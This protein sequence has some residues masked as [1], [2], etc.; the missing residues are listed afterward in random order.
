[1]RDEHQVQDNGDDI[2]GMGNSIHRT[3][4][5]PAWYGFQRRDAG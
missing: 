5:T 3:V 1:M 2:V 4:A